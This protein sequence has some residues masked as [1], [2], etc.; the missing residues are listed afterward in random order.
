MK[1][2]VPPLRGIAALVLM[3]SFAL[4]CPKSLAADNLVE[5]G[6]FESGLDGWEL[7]IGPEFKDAGAVATALAGTRTMPSCSNANSDPQ[8]PMPHMTS[9][10]ISRMP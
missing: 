3:A 10:A 4:V 1:S 7:F 9:S 5:N 8:R 6:D 2:T